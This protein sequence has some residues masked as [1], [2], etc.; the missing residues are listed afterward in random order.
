VAKEGLLETGGSWHVIDEYS[1]S[2]V[3]KQFNDDSC[4]A[5]YGE[6]LLRGQLCCAEGKA[7]FKQLNT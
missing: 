3:V 6:M 4:V 5:A 1:N 7:E 2:S